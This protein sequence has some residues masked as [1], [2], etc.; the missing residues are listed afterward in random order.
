[1]I[2]LWWML[3][4]YFDF[5]EALNCGHK[6]RKTIWDPFRGEGEIQKILGPRFTYGALDKYLEGFGSSGSV[7]QHEYHI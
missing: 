2:L 6:L 1:M 7:A 4:Q 5:Q 3:T